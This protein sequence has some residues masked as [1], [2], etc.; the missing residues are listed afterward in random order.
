MISADDV[1]NAVA[2][3]IAQPPNV[4]IENI[5]LGNLSGSL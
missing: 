1:A 5:T 3:A 2:Y 4:L